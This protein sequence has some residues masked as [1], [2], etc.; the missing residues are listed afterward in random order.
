MTNPKTPW[1]Q[2]VDQAMQ[3][4]I[5]AFGEGPDKVTIAHATGDTTPYAVDGIFDAQSIDA[6]PDTGVP[7]ISNNPM[8][9]FCVSSLR[10]LL[11]EGDTVTLRGVSYRVKA[12]EY[13]GQGTV[14]A[15]LWRV[16]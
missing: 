7:V 9:S 6:D 3:T 13:D 4:C 10:A 8:V 1:E 11:D 15:F 16:S 2:A 12:V 5:D 14:T